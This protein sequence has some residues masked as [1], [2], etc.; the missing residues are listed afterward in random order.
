MFSVSRN[1]LKQFFL[2]CGI[3]AIMTLENIIQEQRILTYHKSSLI[4]FQ[5][6]TF[7]KTNKT[8]KKQNCD[9]LSPKYK[10]KD[11]LM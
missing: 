4:F 11:I 2:A 6:R 8:N 10:K 7:K 9:M 3:S 1:T 5:E